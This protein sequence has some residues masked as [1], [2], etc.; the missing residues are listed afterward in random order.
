MSTD[1]GAERNPTARCARKRPPC[2]H[3]RREHGNGQ[4]FGVVFV[5]GAAYGVAHDCLCKGHIDPVDK[6]RFPRQGESILDA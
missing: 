2:G 5:G 1:H 4:C 6:P 3:Q